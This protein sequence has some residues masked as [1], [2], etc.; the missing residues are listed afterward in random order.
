MRHIEFWKGKMVVIS[1]SGA[2]HDHLY[3]SQ[4]NLVTKYI[5]LGGHGRG[6]EIDWYRTFYSRDS[7]LRLL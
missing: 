5:I 2:L 4:I 1:D 7:D 3:L 6:R